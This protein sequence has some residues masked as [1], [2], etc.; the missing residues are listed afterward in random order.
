V[1]QELKIDAVVDFLQVGCI[2]GKNLKRITSQRLEN[3]LGIPTLDLEGREHFMSEADRANMNKKLEEFLDMCIA[4][5][6]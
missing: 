1:C 6:N 4:N 5:K 2:T 3:E